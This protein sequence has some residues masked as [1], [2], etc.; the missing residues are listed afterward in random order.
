MRLRALPLVAFATLSALTATPASAAPT[1]YTVDAVHS[2]VLFRVK[3]M[4]VANAYGRFNKFSGSITLD[5]ANP[6]SCGVRMEI[7]VAS[8]DTG[9]TSRDDHL[10]NADFF[11]AAQFPKMTFVSTAIKKTGDEYEV[12]G[13]L[14]LHGV[15]KSVVA[16]MTKT[17]QGKSRDGKPLVGF[18]GTLDVK[19]SDFGVGKPPPGL[20]D[21]VRLTISVEAVAQ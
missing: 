18:E 9:N 14:T 20:A 2:Y 6:A 11:N 12:T 1:T 4:D 15:T 3:H 7:D 13:N 21:E 5:E 19:R 10:R 17:G 8:I 16:K